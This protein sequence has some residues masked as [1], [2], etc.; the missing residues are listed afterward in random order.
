MMSAA[1]PDEPD[2]IDVLEIDYLRPPS[3]YLTTT[4]ELPQKKVNVFT[5]EL[6]INLLK[7]YNCL[8]VHQVF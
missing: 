4:F 1:N 8:Y 3:A 5:G 7:Q 6:F 2:S